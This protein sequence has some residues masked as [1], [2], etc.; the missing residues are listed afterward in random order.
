MIHGVSSSILKTCIMKVSYLSRRSWD[1]DETG[2]WSRLMFLKLLTIILLV[3]EGV[4]D[5]V[6][7]SVDIMY[8]GF[9]GVV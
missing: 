5:M 6:V 7:V 9:M 2:E 1:G 8:T 4:G 3:V